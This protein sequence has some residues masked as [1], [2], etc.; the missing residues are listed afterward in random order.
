MG[1]GETLKILTY[2]L[3]IKLCFSKSYEQSLYD[4]I[5]VNDPWRALVRISTRMPV[6]FFGLKFGHML[7]FGL[8]ENSTFMGLK[9]LMS[10]WG[11]FKTSAILFGGGSIKN[12]IM[13]CTNKLEA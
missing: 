7:S 5:T 8:L 11:Q 2:L 9:K 12:E 3:T 13:P 6:S 4:V 1:F 10:F